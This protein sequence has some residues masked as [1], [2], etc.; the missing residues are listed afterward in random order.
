[1]YANI[2]IEISHENVDR[3]FQYKIPPALSDVL[4]PGVSVTVPF[5]KSNR[6]ITGVIIELTN[7]AEYPPEKL[8]EIIGITETGVNI[9]ADAIRLAEWMKKNYGGT[10]IAAL[11]TVLPVKRTFKPKEKK[12]V[13]RLVSR[14][15]IQTA[16]TESV[17]KKQTAK[18]RILTELLNEEI[19]PYELVTGKLHVTAATLKSLK[20]QGLIA[21]DIVQYYRN[22][23]KLSAEQNT[24]PILSKEQ[25]KI[26]D[27]VNNDYHLGSRFTYLIRGITGSGKTEVYMGLIENVLA[28]GKQCIVLIPEIA[29]TYQTLLRFYKRFGD[30]VSVINSSLSAG[31]KYDQC[32]RAKRGEIDIIIG[33]RSALFVPFPALGLIIIV[34]KHSA[35]PC[36][37]G[38]TPALFK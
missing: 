20:N 29:L 37:P 23:V 25:Q 35:L 7:Q 10:M 19:L 16:L 6:R 1:L 33:P 22:P 14:T 2:I 21:I 32:E 38:C 28:M 5:G 18:A 8:K 9:S 4:T 15:E 3:P 27:T 26:V 36:A 34:R 24:K 13:R 11:K 12:T 17:N 31:E 30:R